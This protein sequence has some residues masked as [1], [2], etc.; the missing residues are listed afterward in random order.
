MEGLQNPADCAS[1]GLLPSELLD[2]VL[3]WNGPDWLRHDVS[4][5]P[6]QPHLP[7]NTPSEDGDEVCRHVISLPTHPVIPVNHYSSFT[8]LKRVTV[9]ILRFVYNCQA[10]KKN[11]TRISSPLTTNEMKRAESYWVSF[12]QAIHFT[13]EIGALKAKVNIPTSSPLRFLNPFLDECGLLRIGG[14]EE[15]S[16]RPYDSCHPLIMHAKSPIATLIIRSEHVRLLHAG[17]LLLSTSLS[18]QFQFIKGRSFFR[19]VTRSCVICQ[20]RSKPD[21]GPVTS[22]TSNTWLCV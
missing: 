5:W 3:W 17:P 21:D 15:H 6:K 18:R 13:R 8:R 12:T 20:L 4:A 19:S 11:L 7:P 14:R 1:R 2:H 22:R 16:K 9:W 10:A